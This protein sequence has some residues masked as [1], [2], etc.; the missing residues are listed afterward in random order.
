MSLVSSGAPIATKD[1]IAF[2]NGEMVRVKA[3]EV[4]VWVSLSPRHVVGLPAETLRMPAILDTAHTHN[5]SIQEQH[6]VRWAGIRPESLR[7][8]G[9]LRQE[10][11]HVPLYA[12]DVW[13]HR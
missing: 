4:I 1:D 7:A 9:N 6:L 2:V 11:R 10:G 13:V 3:Y 5:F 8:L 12:A